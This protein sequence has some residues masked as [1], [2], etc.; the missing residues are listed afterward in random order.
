VEIVGWVAWLLLQLF[1]FY[2]NFIRLHPET[3]GGRFPFRRYL[4]YGGFSLFNE[5]GNTILGVSTDLFIITA[6]LGPTAVAYYAFAD[7]VIKM[8]SHCMPHVI[9]IDVIRPSFFTKYAESNSN[10]RL[11]DSFNLLVKVGAFCV[12]P[13]A[14]GVI[15]LGDE[16]IAVIFKPEY[17]NAKPILLI[18]IVF[19]AINVFAQPSGL[20]LKAIERVQTIMYSKIFAIYNLVAAL[21][22]IQRF[23]VIGVVLTTCSAHLMTNLFLYYYARKF[24]GM[25]IEWN[26]LL[27]ISVNAIVM[28]L[29]LLIFKP[30]ITGVLS[31]V[32]VSLL[33]I[34]IYLLSSYL[35]KA[36]SITERT[37]INGLLPKKA[38]LF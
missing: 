38:F 20:V 9:L 15:L 34:A 6:F 18:M 26:G 1:F 22:V 27:K 12:F 4:R 11:I 35:N 3:Q 17:L 5:Y 33:G 31:L 29:A 21:I 13:V 14:A 10:K 36:F 28:A 30:M 32:L 23:G 25:R 37:W 8:L 7:R 2:T 24:V 19:T 16:F